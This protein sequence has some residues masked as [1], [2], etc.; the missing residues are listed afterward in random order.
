MHHFLLGISEHSSSDPIGFCRSLFMSFENEYNVLAEELSGDEGDVAPL[1][2]N[3]SPTKGAVPSFSP[4]LKMESLSL[5]DYTQDPEIPAHPLFHSW[6]FWFHSH[7]SFNKGSNAKQESW[8]SDL[9]QF[10]SVSTVEQLWAYMNYLVSPSALEFNC[11][12]H[13]FKNPIRPEWEDERNIGGGR[14]VLFIKQ[15][16]KNLDVYWENLLLALSGEQLE[17]SDAVNGAV[18][19]RRKHMDKIAIWTARLDSQEQ[20]DALGAQIKAAV[21]DECPFP[22]SFKMEFSAHPTA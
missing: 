21:A 13:F 14:W 1:Q 10:G 20:I 8:F 2:I 11:N 15:D 16:R 3:T 9:K 7:Q 17:L 19:S 12:Y 5:N 18:I 4:A 22:V 6:G